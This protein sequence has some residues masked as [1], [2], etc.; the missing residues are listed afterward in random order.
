MGA[1]LFSK[2]KSNHF[3]ANAR[4]DAL[5]TENVFISHQISY[6]FRPRSGSRSMIM[7]QSLFLFESQSP[8]V[9]N[10]IWI[11]LSVPFQTNMPETYVRSLPL[12]VSATMK[13]VDSFEK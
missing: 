1:C 7:D 12:E 8:Q 13:T 5:I 4:H 6:E 2:V 11:F 10:E 3:L 9:Y